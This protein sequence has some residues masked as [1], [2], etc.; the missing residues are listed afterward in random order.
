[1]LGGLKLALGTFR[2]FNDSPGR[3]LPSLLRG[4]REAQ[5]TVSTHLSAQVLGALDSLLLFALH[6]GTGALQTFGVDFR[7]DGVSKRASIL[8]LDA[9]IG[10][11]V[12]DTRF[13][14]LANG[15]QLL[16]NGLGLTH[17]RLEHNILRPLSV[18][19]IAAMHLLCR[20]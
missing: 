10:E 4:S 18:N 12:G 9:T 15:P 3:R 11:A 13:N 2:L 1:M 6:I 16:A 8:P 5:A 19:E 7:R 20:L 14:D 17:Q